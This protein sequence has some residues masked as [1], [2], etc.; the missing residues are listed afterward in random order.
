[1]EAGNAQFYAEKAVNS[2]YLTAKKYLN[3]A[4]RES[5]FKFIGSA[6]FMDVV[7]SIM[8]GR[9]TFMNTQLFF[10]P[11]N[12]GQ[13]NYWHRDPQY[14]MSIDEQKQAL[15]DQTLS[16]FEFLLSD[17]PGIELIPGTHRRWD[18]DDEL[19]VALE[20]NGRKSHDKPIDW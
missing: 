5:L 2:A 1:M 6:K 18:N 15:L 19:D 11:V 16:T 7:V 8:G 14:H 4:G 9:P 17:E 20:G 10:D 13:K 3:S 12:E